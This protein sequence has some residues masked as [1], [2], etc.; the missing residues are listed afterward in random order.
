MANNVDGTQVPIPTL[1]FITVNAALV[2]NA[3]PIPT[4]PPSTSNAPVGAA[5]PIPTFPVNALIPG[6][7]CVYAPVLV[8]PVV[9]VI[10]PALLTV[11]A[12]APTDNAAFGAHVPM[13]TLPSVTRLACG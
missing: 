11:N 7:L 13:P 4:L 10:A 8:I 1:P 2:V 12:F 3:V 5:V 6:P 9:A